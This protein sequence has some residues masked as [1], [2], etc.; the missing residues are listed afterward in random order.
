MYNPDPERF[1]P[2]SPMAYIGYGL[3]FLIPI[4]G[5]VCAIIFAR[6][7]SN[8]NLRCYCRAFLIT[9]ASLVVLFSVFA[10]I[11]FA[12][13]Q[14]SEVIRRIPDAFKVLFP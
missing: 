1:R 10:L 6:R 5:V 12:R 3:L 11:L 4:A 7:S 2:L 13:G 8:V 14:L 9:A